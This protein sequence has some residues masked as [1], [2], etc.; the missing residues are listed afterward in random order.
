M[1]S[2]NR[3]E[4]VDLPSSPPPTV[5][6]HYTQM[7]S[8]S[9]LTHSTRCLLVHLGCPQPTKTPD[10]VVYRERG[11][12][13]EISPSSLKIETAILHKMKIVCLCDKTLLMQEFYKLHSG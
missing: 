6:P 13:A 12:R 2:Y 4:T 8:A 7:T 10:G 9:T 5:P 1:F 11:G 3:T